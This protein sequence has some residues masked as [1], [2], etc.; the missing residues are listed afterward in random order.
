M[1][2]INTATGAGS[3]Y[4][5][6]TGYQN[7]ANGFN[8]LYFNST[9]FNNTAS[10]YASLYGNTTGYNNTAV[11][12]GAFNNNTIGN[13]N[14]ALGAYSD[15][16]VGSSNINNAT[17]IGNSAK[18]NA[19]NKIRLGS[20]SVTVIEGQVAYSFPSDGRFKTNVKENTPGLDFI[21]KLKPV[22]YNFQYNKFS[23]FL[24]ENNPDNQLLDQRESQ[25][26]MGFIAQEVE[27]TCKEL[28]IEV[29][30]ILHSP[31]S[32][33]DNYSLAYQN[34]VVPLVKGM[35][36]QQKTIEQHEKSIEEYKAALEDMQQKY[37][38]LEAKLN[39]LMASG[40]NSSPGFSNS[41]L[42]ISP[43]PAAGNSTLSFLNSGEK[44]MVKVA[45]DC[46]KQ[47]WQTN[48]ASNT[49]IIPSEKFSAGVYT[50]TVVKSSGAETTRL[51]IAK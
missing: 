38:S 23:E 20:S 10:G 4:S 22:T 36:E 33:I 6:T 50:V 27:K 14:T 32:E 51:V 16:S 48:T 21:M 18:V 35:Q 45:D 5:N 26:E 19:S 9:G 49:V 31:E 41:S 43:N 37:E 39:A 12:F 2:Y 44:V 29:S 42:K 24:K 46:G 47:I 30:N 11:G 15:I 17:V 8:S 1:G 28:G 25:K 7:T 34:L 13:F 3:L 40:I